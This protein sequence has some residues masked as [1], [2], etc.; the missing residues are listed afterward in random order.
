MKKGLNGISLG[1]KLYLVG[2]AVSVACVA[3][4]A[5]AQGNQARMSVEPPVEQVKK[6]GPNFKVDIVADNVANLAAFQFS[7]AYDPSVIKYV[8]VTP[9][10]FLGST[11]RGL[12]CPDPFVEEGNP[13]TLRFNCV[14]LGAPVSL[15]GPAGPD[16]YGSLAEVTFSPVGG[17][18]TP[19]D[20]KEGILLAAEID[21]KGAPAQ[22]ETA[23]E[24]ASL[25]IASSGGG[26]PWVLWGP[27]I[28]VVCVA[29]VVGVVVLVMRRRGGRGLGTLGGS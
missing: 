18:K 29:V 2:V 17:G 27:V 12:R 19:L 4:I 15:G 3:G 24:G 23:V 20:L 13:E 26:F 10:T 25:E 6:G 7:L 1:V 11:G 9:T 5:F 28:G 8:A 14:T 21:A 16:G 22:I